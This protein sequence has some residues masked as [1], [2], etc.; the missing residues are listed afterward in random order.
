M[1]VAQ[2]GV[3]VDDA[4]A[5]LRA[6][7]YAHERKLTD[8]AKDVVDRRLDFSHSADRKGRETS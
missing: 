2:L 5:L 7:A 4:L 3:G 1:V 8:I 6:H